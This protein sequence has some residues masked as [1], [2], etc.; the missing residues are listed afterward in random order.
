[1]SERMSHINGSAS[2]RCTHVTP[3][4]RMCLLLGLIRQRETGLA[5]VLVDES[6]VAYEDRGDRDEGKEVVRL[7]ATRRGRVA[8]QASKA[9][10]VSRPA[11]LG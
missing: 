3:G 8:C 7:L 4:V 9:S 1:M 11:C 5:A 6:A 10:G 2:A